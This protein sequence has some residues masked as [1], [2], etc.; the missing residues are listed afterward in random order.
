[1]RLLVLLLIVGCSGSCA[2][3][4]GGTKVLRPRYHKVWA[5]GNKYLIDIPVGA[6]HIRLFERRRTKVVS[7]K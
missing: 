1:M 4:K 6:R 5:K 3:Q 2:S 7:M